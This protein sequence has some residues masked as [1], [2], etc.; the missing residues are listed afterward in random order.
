M[1]T[2]ISTE[3]QHG[4]ANS[5]LGKKKSPEKHDIDPQVRNVIETTT[6]GGKTSDTLIEL[7]PASVHAQFIVGQCTAQWHHKMH[8]PGVACNNF[9]F[10]CN[11]QLRERCILLITLCVRECT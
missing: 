4:F 6:A 7:L 10:S 5:S 11:D 1:R 9:S 3:D 2:T 8:T